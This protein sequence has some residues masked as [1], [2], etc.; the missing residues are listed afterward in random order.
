MNVDDDIYRKHRR[1]ARVVLADG[2]ERVLL[3]SSWLES[4]E[5]II[6]LAPG[7]ALEEGEGFE[8]AAR[9]ECWEETG[10][11]L[12]G[13]LRHVWTREHDWTWHGEPI[14]TF[15]HYYFARVERF[16]PQ[17]RQLEDYEEE[18]FRGHEWWSAAQ[19]RASE[20]L[21]VPRGIGELVVPL[22]RGEFPSSPVDTSP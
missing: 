6:W 1:A 10:L 20:A 21:L 11:R 22:L 15:E 3:L 4:K 13:P 17:A 14:R 19:L 2:A 5:C 8:E 12:E 9:R 18:L 16:E 7:G